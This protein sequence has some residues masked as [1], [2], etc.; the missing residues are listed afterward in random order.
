MRPTLTIEP[1]QVPVR[2]TPA[3]RQHKSL[4][5]LHQRLVAEANAEGKDAESLPAWYVATASGRT[6]RIKWIGT[7][8]P[9][10]RFV[11]IDDQTAVLVAPEAVS[12]TIEPIPTESAAPGFKIGFHPPEEQ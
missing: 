6:M 2:L 12:I 8:G 10:V 9:F 5:E 3:E 11:G 7:Y 1:L 4:L